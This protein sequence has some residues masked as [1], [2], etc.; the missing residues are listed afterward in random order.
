MTGGPADQWEVEESQACDCTDVWYAD[1]QG[2]TFI[3]HVSSL[4]LS[5]A[6]ST[7]QGTAVTG[8][9]DVVYASPNAIYIG[10]SEWDE[11]LFQSNDSALDTV[12]HKFDIS[13][14]GEKPQYVATGQ[15][16]GVLS[17]QF[18]L[19][20]KDGILRVATERGW[21]TF[22]EEWELYHQRDGQLPMLRFIGREP[23]HLLRSLPGLSDGDMT[24]EKIKKAMASAI[25]VKKDG[26]NETAVLFSPI[27]SAI[28]PPLADHWFYSAHSLGDFFTDLLRLPVPQYLFR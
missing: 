18:A 1:R 9:A 8:R 26:R 23:M 25:Q 21:R 22:K 28:S 6:G 5:Q 16:E 14:A 10:Y 4:D 2:G 7:F 11:G 13:D 15:V 19:S 27:T 20:E 24:D 17:D 3:T 12:L